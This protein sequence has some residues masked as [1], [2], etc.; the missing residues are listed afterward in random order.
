M[1]LQ[2][3]LTL[4][5][6]DRFGPQRDGDRAVS[7]AER[8]LRF[9]GPDRAAARVRVEDLRRMVLAMR[10][11][12]LGPASVNRY[13]SA[14]SAVL[15]T[16]GVELEMPWQREPKGRTRWLSGEE[17][18]LLAAA[19]TQRCLASAALIRFLAE[20]GLRRG[21][22]LAL[23]WADVDTNQRPQVRVQ[24]S[25][26]GEQRVVPL[27]AEAVTALQQRRQVAHER[28][29]PW[30]DL[31]PSRFNHVFRWAR[32]QVASLRGNREVV[33]HALRHTAASRLVRAGVSLPIVQAWLGHRSFQSTLRYVH[34][35]QA[36]LEAAAKMLEDAR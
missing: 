30:S 20:T 21:E 4:T 14:L 36:G 6:R 22:A 26:N 29:G 35:D 28:P 8:C 1:N 15:E 19:A 24:R 13:L 17:V 23:T 34:P 32:D 9:L 18:G 11:T 27:T 3:A 33:P 5:T 12:G 2:H 16:A 10:E 7:R 31:S 25:K